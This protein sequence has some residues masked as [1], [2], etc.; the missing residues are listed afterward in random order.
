MFRFLAKFFNAKV[1]D[2]EADL[3]PVD[4]P[5]HGGKG[6]VEISKWNDGSAEIEI[7]LKHSELPNG[8]ILEVYC[9]DKKLTSLTT[10]FGSDKKHLTAEFITHLG[11]IKEG[12]SAEFRQRGQIL[13]QGVFRA[14]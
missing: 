4:D 12:D 13:Y 7:S 8:T 6:E 14:D 1:L 2:L 5:N 3:F 11:E 10:K 9:K